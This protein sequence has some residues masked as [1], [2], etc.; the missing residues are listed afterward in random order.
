MVELYYSQQAKVNERRAIINKQQ[1]KLTSNPIYQNLKNL[2]E[3]YLWWS[4]IIVNKQELTSNEQKLTSN[5]QK[6][7]S[8]E[9]GAKSN[10]QV[11]K[12]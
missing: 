6:V 1:A 10:E 8:N 9:Q 5:E 2:H 3:K 11:V 12:K 4:F 7:T